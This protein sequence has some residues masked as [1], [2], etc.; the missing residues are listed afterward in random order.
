MP[1][2][3]GGEFDALNEAG[4][5]VHYSQQFLQV[6]GLERLICVA[7]HI[8]FAEAQQLVKEMDAVAGAR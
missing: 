3:G 2:P 8:P 1:G 5:S 6:D 7:G 4:E